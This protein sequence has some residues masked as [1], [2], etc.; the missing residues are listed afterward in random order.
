MD[1]PQLLWRIGLDGKPWIIRRG[2]EVNEPLDKVMRKDYV[3]GVVGV[4][5]YCA[6]DDAI[7]YSSNHSW[8]W[9]NS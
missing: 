8:D 1:F 7:R 4:L 2:N 5:D 3:Y 9:L 6:I